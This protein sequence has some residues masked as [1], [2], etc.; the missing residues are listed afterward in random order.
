MTGCIDLGYGIALSPGTQPDFDYVNANMRKAD[1][2]E[3]EVFGEGGERFDRWEQAWSIRDGDDIIGIIGFCIF[4]ME[5]PMSRNRL[6]CF[7]S[8]DAV[9]SR[10]VKFVRRSRLVFRRVAGMCRPWVTDFYSLPM[11]EYRQ[12]IRWQ[13]RILGFRRVAEDEFRGVKHTV[14][15][16]R[17]NEV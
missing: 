12:S 1:R 16:I 3:C 11:S 14:L 10:K 13:E 17:R 15:H 7:L 5:S 9:W 6:F 8:T 2:R 4:G